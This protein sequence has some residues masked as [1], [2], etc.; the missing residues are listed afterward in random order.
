MA[1][2]ILQHTG[3]GKAVDWWSL[4]TLMYDML[5]GA[6]PFC[7]ETILTKYLTTI[8]EAKDLIEGTHPPNRLGSGAKPIKLYYCQ[9]R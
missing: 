8:A 6:P 5:T 3:Y 9:G 1:P 4:R 7:K 2:E